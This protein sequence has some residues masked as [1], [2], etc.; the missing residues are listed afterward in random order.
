MSRVPR[1]VNSNSDIALALDTQESELENIQ[2]IKEGARGVIIPASGTMKTAGGSSVSGASALH[3]KHDWES[4]D[5][6]NEVFIIPTSGEE[7]KK[8]PVRGELDASLS[9]SKR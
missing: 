6:E 5:T 9:L 4:V 1:E 7:K 3:D 2:Q 8:L